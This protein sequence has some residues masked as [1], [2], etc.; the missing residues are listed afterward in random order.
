MRFSENVVYPP[1]SPF[2]IECQKSF[3][4]PST[5]ATFYVHTRKNIEITS[6]LVVSTPLKNMSQL[7]FWEI[8]FLNME[9]H[10]KFHGSSHHQPDIS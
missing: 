1:K 4:N 3:E 8:P 7:G 10:S 6:W 5:W 9:S 2:S